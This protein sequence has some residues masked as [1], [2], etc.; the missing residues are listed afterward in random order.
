MWKKSFGAA[1]LVAARICPSSVLLLEKNDCP[2]KMA[3]EIYRK[4]WWGK[5][6]QLNDMMSL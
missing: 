3:R 6:D 5:D 4:Y 2:Y 1:V